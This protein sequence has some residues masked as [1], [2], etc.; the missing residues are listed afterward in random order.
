MVYLEALK[1]Y[2]FLFL[3]T[4][5]YV[6]LFSLIYFFYLLIFFKASGQKNLFLFSLG[7]YLIFLLNSL[8]FIVILCAIFFF[9][10]LTKEKK[11][12]LQVIPIVSGFNTVV[13]FIFF[14]VNFSF[15]SVY[16]EKKLYYTPAVREG[17]L[18]VFGDYRFYYQ[19][20]Q[21]GRFKTGV[22]FYQIPYLISSLRVDE[23]SVVLTTSHSIEA[24][25]IAHNA[26]TFYI[27]RSEGLI[28]LRNTPISLF[29]LK[30]YENYIE[31][32][33][34]FF[35]ITFKTSGVFMSFLSIFL[36]LTGFTSLVA[37][38]SIYFGDKDL[39]FLSFS[40]IL[41]IS[42]ALFSVFPGFL[43]LSHLIK[44]GIRNWLFETILPS[45]CVGLFAGMIGYGLIELRF[46]VAK[47]TGNK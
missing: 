1:K 15:V 6:A 28:G 34:D 13:L 25:G 9:A 14:I 10:F 4:L 40:V 29:L 27:K 19:T 42:V 43:G 18:N 11:F 37:G 3:K 2:F 7:N 38:V 22:L 5:I 41:V 8:P 17:Y 39:I 45:F 35:K 16:E 36:L 24:G 44:L 23:N 20:D 12:L 26:K 33:R 46:L 31:K 32:L 21:K 47:M 30:M